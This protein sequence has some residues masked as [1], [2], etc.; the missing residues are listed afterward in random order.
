MIVGDSV[1]MGDDDTEMSSVVCSAGRDDEVVV[2]G[3]LVD[4]DW[5]KY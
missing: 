4:S 5:V 3:V 1:Q 2:G